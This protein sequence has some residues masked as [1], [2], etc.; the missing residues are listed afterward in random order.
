MGGQEGVAWEERR[1]WHWQLLPG[2]ILGKVYHEVYPKRES[3][4]GTCYAIN[5]VTILELELMSWQKL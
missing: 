1:V 3:L 2:E 5:D 4:N